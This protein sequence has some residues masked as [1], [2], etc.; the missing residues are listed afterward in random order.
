[1]FLFGPAVKQGIVGRH[2]SLTDLDGGDLKY[3]VDFR[4]IYA[5]VMQN[6]LDA[7]SKPVLGGQFPTL[8]LLRA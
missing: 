4:S 8:P 7:P 3:N 6:W 5:T 1:M 2:P